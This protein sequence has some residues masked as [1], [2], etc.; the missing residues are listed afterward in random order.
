L[1]VLQQL[2]NHISRHELLK[3][4]ERVLVAV[5]GGLD[6]MVLLDLLLKSGISLGVAHCNFQLRPSE[7]QKEEEFVNE[8][9]KSRGVDCF[10]ARFDTAEYA[11]KEKISTQVAAR[12][13]RYEFF[14]K[15]VSENG[16]AKIA[17]AHHL[18][19]SLETV[20]HNLIRGTGL[21]GL[22]GIPVKNGS[23]IRP[24][25]F[26][27]RDMIL[28]YANREGVKWCEDSS[29][30]SVDYTRN[31][32]RHKVLPLLKEIN[33]SLEETFRDSLTR[34]VGSKVLYE[35]AVR[36]WKKNIVEQD[37]DRIK[38]SKA[39]LHESP[40]PL[41]LLWELIKPFGFHFDQMERILGSDQPG[42]V[43]SSHEATLL[44]D[45]DFYLIESSGSNG[46][47]E[48]KIADF[49]SEAVLAT[50]RLRFNKVERFSFSS[51][52]PSI[53]FVDP[54]ML[55]QPLVW[56]TW[57]EG[58]AF[59]PFGMQHRK[60]IS[61]FLIDMKI[62]LLAKRRVTVL[63]SAGEILWVVGLRA[64]ERVRITNTDSSVI[65]IRHVKASGH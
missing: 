40:S 5:S 34:I 59:I 57:K 23:V 60:K 42:K 27:S 55:V 16:Y 6:S 7:A 52:D 53:V 58:D 43:F 11:E 13:L 41:V 29:N 46:Y 26:A 19:D 24:M 18:N 28:A 45:R 1:R 10:T 4:G 21:D 20:L 38:I 47:A 3:P 51:A 63:E 30:T 35:G 44:N 37:H 31:F 61:D 39:R 14:F 2:L 32:I 9:C 15:I 64:S 50:E 56:R 65:C 17:T 62:D 48:T 8:F 54:S 25:L 36:E 12:R 22:A 49:S 33:P